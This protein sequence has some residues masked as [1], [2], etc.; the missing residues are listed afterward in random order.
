MEAAKKVQEAAESYRKEA[1]ERLKE[2]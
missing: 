1:E 2:K